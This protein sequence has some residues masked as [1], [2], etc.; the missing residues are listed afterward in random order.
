M[1]VSIGDRWE[2]FV[3]ELVKSGRYSSASEVMREGLRL[4]EERDARLKALHQRECP[5]VCVTSPRHAV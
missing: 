5:E 2:S 1:N 3:D 4:V